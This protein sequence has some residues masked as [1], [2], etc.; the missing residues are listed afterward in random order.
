M[1]LAAKIGGSKTV[2]STRVRGHF[3]IGM[4][5]RKQTK[6][7]RQTRVDDD[8]REHVPLLAHHASSSVDYVD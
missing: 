8:V 3:V 5:V 1:E 2:S 6:R 7:E 4:T